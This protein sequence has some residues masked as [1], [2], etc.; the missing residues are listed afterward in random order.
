MADQKLSPS[1]IPAK[2]EI[3]ESK[4]TKKRAVLYTRVSTADQH[5][6]T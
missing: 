4:L 2:V 5:P 1:T 6:E 3:N